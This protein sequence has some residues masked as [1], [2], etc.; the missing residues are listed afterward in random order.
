MYHS[1]EILL[2]DC[3]PE[4]MVLYDL[5]FELYKIAVC[6]CMLIF[7]VRIDKESKTYQ[8]DI[9]ASIQKATDHHTR[10]IDLWLYILFGLV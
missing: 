2:A 9:T 1:F 5:G 3:L 4:S 6:S 7:C 10:C 8:S